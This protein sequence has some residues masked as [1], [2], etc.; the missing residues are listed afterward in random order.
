VAANKVADLAALR[1]QLTLRGAVLRLLVD[2]LDQIGFLEL[3]EP[4]LAS[5]Q[6]WSVFVKVDAGGKSVSSLKI[7]GCVQL[8]TL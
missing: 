1:E 4:S 2:H 6:K 7:H 8:T 3:H 5:P